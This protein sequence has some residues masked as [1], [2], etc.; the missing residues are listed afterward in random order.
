MKKYL[1]DQCFNAEALP[2]TDIFKY[3]RRELTNQLVKIMEEA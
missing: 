2:E 1:L 3:S